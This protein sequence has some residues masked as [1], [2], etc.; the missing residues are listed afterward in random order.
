MLTQ[1]IDTNLKR[2]LRAYA[3]AWRNSQSEEGKRVI[4]ASVIVYLEG[5]NIDREII[6]NYYTFYDDTKSSN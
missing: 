2:E 3:E 5:F 6:S 1:E 4:D